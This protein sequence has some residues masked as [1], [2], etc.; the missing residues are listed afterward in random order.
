M[1]VPVLPEGE[2][3][4][5]LSPGRMTS[6]RLADPAVIVMVEEVLGVPAPEAVKDWIPDVTNDVLKT[7]VPAVSGRLPGGGTLES[8]VVMVTDAGLLEVVTFQ[9][10]S[11][12]LMV[13]VTGLPAV[14][15]SGG[16]FL[17][18]G[19]D[20]LP[21]ALLSPKIKTCKPN[22]TFASTLMPVC[23]LVDT[24]GTP[25]PATVSE[26]FIAILIGVKPF[27]N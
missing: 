1:G 18:A 25:T 21:P 27:V 3:W 16:E 24:T 5:W 14:N 8:V 4:D 13:M 11:T 26:R 12:A 15:C 22:V 9:Y 23:V 6:I 7:V 2:P 19:A 10:W 20:N 17:P